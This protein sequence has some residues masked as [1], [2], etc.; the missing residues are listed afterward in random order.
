LR[1]PLFSLYVY[2]IYVRPDFLFI[3]LDAKSSFI[4][5][6]LFWWCASAAAGPSLCASDLLPHFLRAPEVMT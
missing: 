5:A 3:H 4:R 1:P 6:K 2:N